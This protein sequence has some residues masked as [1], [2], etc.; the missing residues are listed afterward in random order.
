[1][2]MVIQDLLD[3]LAGGDVGGT[4]GFAGRTR[5]MMKT[6]VAVLRV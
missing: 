1:M 3:V 2:V 6:L 5:A 4:M